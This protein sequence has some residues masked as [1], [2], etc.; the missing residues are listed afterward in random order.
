MRQHFGAIFPFV[1]LFI[2]LEIFFVEKSKWV[3]YRL[4]QFSAKYTLIPA[5]L[6]HNQNGGLSL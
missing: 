6:F 4:A 1:S 3:C 5:L 2:E